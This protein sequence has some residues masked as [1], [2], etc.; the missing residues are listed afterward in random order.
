VKNVYIVGVATSCCIVSTV[1][2][3]VDKGFKVFVISDAC[4][5][6]TNENHK[7]GIK[8]MSGYFPMVEIIET[9]QIPI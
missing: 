4:L 2:K 7:N 1:L 3:L 8:L 9:N 6:D 5:D